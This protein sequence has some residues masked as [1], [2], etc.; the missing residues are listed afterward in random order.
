MILMRANPLRWPLGPNG[1][2]LRPLAF[3]RSTDRA[4]TMI[5][6]GKIQIL[7]LEKSLQTETDFGSCWTSFCSN[8]KLLKTTVAP[9][10]LVHFFIFSMLVNI[11]YIYD[12]FPSIHVKRRI[13]K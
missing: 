2:S 13:K 3:V 6:F 11:S 8:I 5:K 9:V 1:N 7:Y 4:A 12:F 10:P